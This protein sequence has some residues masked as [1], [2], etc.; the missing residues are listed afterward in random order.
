MRT[1]YCGR[2]HMRVEELIGRRV[3]HLRDQKGL[4]GDQ[5]AQRVGRWLGPQWNRKT[6]W[7]VEAGKR[8]FRIVELFAL[9]YALD[10]GVDGLLLLYD[11]STGKPLREIE[12]PTGEV[13]DFTPKTHFTSSWLVRVDVEELEAALSALEG[14][15]RELTRHAEV[16]RSLRDQR[17]EMEEY[18]REEDLEFFNKIDETRAREGERRRG[19]NE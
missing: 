9:A 18:E 12:M 19:G 2:G 6:V 13:I 11:P 15:G 8:D 4:T 14:A 7:Q 3:R 10:V 16:I 1:C 17:K 5:L